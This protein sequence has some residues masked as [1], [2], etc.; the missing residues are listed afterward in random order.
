MAD[1]LQFADK[2]ALTT[3]K[4]PWPAP[5][6]PASQQSSDRYLRL[7]ERN[8]FFDPIF[9]PRP[10]VLYCVKLTQYINVKK[11]LIAPELAAHFTKKE[12]NCQQAEG[13]WCAKNTSPIVMQVLSQTTCKSLR[14]K[15]K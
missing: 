1:I 14:E 11:G 5:K 8:D 10:S 3:G 13:R 4:A 2:R 7:K 9:V 15:H 6:G 12:A